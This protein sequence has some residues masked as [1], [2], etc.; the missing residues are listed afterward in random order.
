M[1]LAEPVTLY[2]PRR[3][4]IRLPHHDYAGGV[5]FVT[6]CAHDRV[7]L[8]G[9]VVD[10]MMVPNALGDIVLEEWIR[11]EEIRAE[12]TLDAFV[13]MPNHVHGIIGIV[14]GA[15]ITDGVGAHGRAPLR[16][17]IAYRRPKSLGAFV[18]GFKSAVTKRINAIRGTPGGKV[19]QRNYWE[20]VLR[21]ERELHIARR[22]VRDN[23][24]RW[25]LDRCH[26][27]HIG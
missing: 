8:F 26:P 11:T 15:T 3:R 24:L 17:G 22:Y 4:S 14:D 1:R 7:L 20:R 18:A 21:D 25:H 27:D 10:G 16:C 5:Y 12:V 2:D 9:D 6:I 23:P 13:V 19:W